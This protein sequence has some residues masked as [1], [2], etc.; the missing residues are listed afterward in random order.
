M[1]TCIPWS[2][3]TP[4]HRARSPG[5]VL[6]RP[7]P[8]PARQGREGKRGSRRSSRRPGDDFF[9]T[10]FRSAVAVHRQGRL[11]CGCRGRFPWFWLSRFRSCSSSTSSW[12]RDRS[13]TLLIPWRCRSRSF[14]DSR[15]HSCCVAEASTHSSKL[16][17]RPGTP[18]CSSW[19]LFARPSLCNDR[20]PPSL[21]LS[22]HSRFL[23]DEVVAALVFDHGGMIMAGFCW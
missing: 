5:Q 10:W 23:V 3:L 7:G 11:R 6:S 14:L 18:Q 4:D 20:Y 13:Q 19:W 1:P 2:Q 12:R 16:C 8:L 22:V 17:K 21:F 15:R 9:L